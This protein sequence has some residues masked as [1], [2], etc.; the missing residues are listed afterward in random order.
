MNERPPPAEHDRS[1]HPTLPQADEHCH[2]ATTLAP[3]LGKPA[4]MRM[5][6]PDLPGYEILSELGC[7]GMGVVYQARDRELNRVV[8][9]KMISSMSQVNPE[10]VARFQREAQAVALMQHPNIVQIH[11]IGTHEGRPFIVLE[12]VAGGSLDRLLHGT[13]WHPRQAA[14]LVIE[15]ARAVHY[16]HQKNVM[17]R[18]LKPAN[19]LLLHATE[20][21]TWDADDFA[22]RV[23]GVDHAPLPSLKITDFGLAKQIDTDCSQTKSGA[24]L[25]TPS[26][27]APE[28]AASETARLSPATDVYALGAILYEL[29]TGRPPFRAATTFDTMMQVLND[30]PVSPRSIQPKIPIDL[31]TICLYCLRKDPQ[32][33]YATAEALA[34]DLQRFLSHE[35]IQARRVGRLE[36]GIKWAK[37]N[38]SR[39]A[40]YSILLITLMLMVILRETTRWELEGA[41]T[42][43]REE[44]DAAQTARRQAEQ[45]RLLAQQRLDQ[46]LAALDRISWVTNERLGRSPS[47]HEE[48]RQI[49]EEVVKLYQ[50]FL[51]TESTEPRVRHDTALAYYQMAKIY[52]SMGEEAQAGDACAQAIALLRDLRERS[53]HHPVYTLDYL[54]CLNARG[55]IHSTQAKMP[56]AL[57]D[58]QEARRLGESLIASMPDSLDLLSET[59]LATIF[60]GH[61]SFGQEQNVETYFRRALELSQMMLEEQEQHPDALCLHAAAHAHLAMHHIKRRDVPQA[62]VYARKALALIESTTLPSPQASRHFAQTRATIH[63]TL[64]QC[65]HLS[66]QPREAIQHGEASLKIYEELLASQ[67]KSFVFLLQCQRASAHLTE[68]LIRVKENEKI[69]PAMQKCLS[70]TN[71]LHE[72]YPAFAPFV[73]QLN[74]SL[75]TWIMLHDIQRGD[76]QKTLSNIER[77]LAQPD[78]PP[79]MLYNYACAYSRA[80][81]AVDKDN[82]F[83]PEEKNTLQERFVRRA[84]ELLLLEKQKG[85]FN[86]PRRIDHLKSDPD[87]DPIRACPEFMKFVQELPS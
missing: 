24:I 15:L 37:R 53:P 12:Y 80:F 76:Y 57:K 86:E 36:R 39:V 67:P 38:P 56:E 49:L 71:Q 65:L 30:D 43:A 14:R 27:M 46:A 23:S 74:P 4:I 1:E 82:R 31:E 44:A 69:E 50:G 87:F 68:L 55:I 16:A 83:S 2:E 63:L 13:P 26:Y 40:F 41:W 45:E 62:A 58:Y 29:L 6:W 85:Y 81:E 3:E 34:A 48:R 75:T 17:H 61:Y 66:S 18:D 51:K 21:Q 9:I 70:F 52:D 47:F 60:C 10:I 77:N 7:G 64:S 35:P 25:G 33:R 8:A 72:L 32:R 19:V 79:G 11:E 78:Q 54:K 22:E 84:V 5:P 42:I 28:Q 20:C 73:A 59:F